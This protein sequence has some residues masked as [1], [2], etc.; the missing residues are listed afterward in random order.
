MGEQVQEEL[1]NLRVGVTKEKKE[2]G[3]QTEQQKLE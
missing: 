2:G 3:L 1:L